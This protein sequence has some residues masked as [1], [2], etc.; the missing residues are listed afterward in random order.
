[1]G[2]IWPHQRNAIDG[3]FVEQGRIGYGYWRM[4][5]CKGSIVRIGTEKRYPQGMTC[6]SLR[7]CAIVGDFAVYP[8][9]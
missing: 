7:L 2:P 8:M 6:L 3:G 4:E 9:Y 1:M 5:P